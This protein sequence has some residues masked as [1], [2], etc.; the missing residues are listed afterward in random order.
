MTVIHS[1]LS[2][3]A[4]NQ[5]LWAPGESLSLRIDS[6][7]TLI[8]DPDEATYDF[9]VGLLGFGIK[10]EAYIDFKIG[11][12]AYASLPDAGSF[13]VSYNIDVNVT[14]PAAVVTNQGA[15]TFT[16]G[17][18]NWKITTADISSV[19]FNGSP[20]AG[21]DLVLGISA[22]I[23]DIEYYYWGGSDTADDFSLV[24]YDGSI[25]LLALSLGVPSIEF[26]LFKGVK[27]VGQ[28]PTG[29]DTEGHSTGST[30]VSASGVS[31]TNFI[32]LAA[33]LDELLIGLL[34][35]IPGAGAVAK[36]LGETVF[37]E[38]E[39]D[40]H[41]YVPF[42][43][44]DKF[45]L[46]AT[47]LDI[48]AS[49]GAAI[50]ESV[51]VDIG[52]GDSTPDV[53]VTLW[54][55]NGTAALGDDGVV[56]TGWLGQNI[57]ITEPTA[58]G[59]GTVNITATY[60]IRNAVFSHTVGLG[61]NASFT[62][63][64]LMASLEG[65]WVPTGLGFELGPLFELTFP[66][67]G[68]S[69]GL[70]DFY[71]DSFRMKAGAFSTDSDTYQIFYTDTAPL[72]WNPDAI[73]AQEA[74]NQYIQFISDNEAST[75]GAVGQ[76]WT[77]PQ[78][79]VTLNNGVV[80]ATGVTNTTYTWSGT[81]LNQLYQLNQSFG[82]EN[83][84][85]VNVTGAAAQN[86][87]LNFI[88]ST[89]GN[90]FSGNIDYQSSAAAKMDALGQL[91]SPGNG[92]SY[93]YGSANFITQASPEIIGGNRGD[94]LVQY[95]NGAQY[96]D[97]AGNA[98]G[99]YDLFMANFLATDPNTSIT[100]DLADALFQN[101]A[102]ELGNGVTVRNVEAMWIVTGNADD[103]IVTYSFSDYVDLSGGND[104]VINMADGAADTI[105]GGAGDDTIHVFATPP[106]VAGL[107]PVIDRIYGGTGKDLAVHAHVSSL[108]LRVDVTE[109]G[110]SLFGAAGLAHDASLIDLTLLTKGHADTFAELL[111]SAINRDN[112]NVSLV[113]INGTPQ[114]GEVV[115]NADIEGISV[116]GSDQSDD[117][118]V[119]SGG[120][121]YIGGDGASSSY[122]TLAGSFSQYEAA[123]G[124]T[125]GLFLRADTA[126]V[127]SGPT[128][129]GDAY[130]DGFERFVIFA[131]GF[132]DNITGGSYQDT[133]VGLDGD[134][135]LDGGADTV[136][137]V[138]VGGNGND[139]LIW[140]NTGADVLLGDG[141][142]GSDDTGTDTLLIEADG[143]E[144]HGLIYDVHLALDSDQ[145]LDGEFGADASSE[146][147][148]W[149]YDSAAL[150][151]QALDLS[152]NA[153]AANHVHAVA[154]GLPNNDGFMVYDGM[155]RVNIIGSVTMD[156]LMIY[157]GG[158][159][160]DGG[161]DADDVDTF[162]A[163]FTTQKIGISLHID[164]DETLDEENNPVALG[165]QGQFL[166]N[167]ILLRGVD[168]AVI[169]AGQ[170]TDFLFGGKFDDYFDG[171]AGSDQLYGSLGNDELH[172]G[173][174]D[175]LVYWFG[176]GDDTATGGAGYDLLTIAGGDGGMS[177]RVNNVVGG[178]SSNVGASD[179]FSTLEDLLQR[180]DVPANVASVVNYAGSTS[181]THSGFEGVNVFGH[182]D[183][184]DLVLYQGGV[185]N[186]GGESAGDADI[187][188]GTF[189]SV[190]ENLDIDVSRVDEDG[191]LRH[192]RHRQRQLLWRVR[193]SFR[194]TGVR[195]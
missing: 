119:F 105:K 128:T 108:E 14:M 189:T 20:S 154:F 45:V 131:S 46:K 184:N 55:D 172:G 41:N 60:D 161:E 135:V 173:D 23:R 27:L 178:T 176:E 95:G 26:D 71:K 147:F 97:G 82:L 40:L 126:L 185:M 121:V 100:W 58:T 5:S 32:E 85:V 123:L 47:M 90:F 148:Y 10:G 63:S 44:A 150:L 96:F 80:N 155:E 109:N 181:V 9:D 49:A 167:G 39:F 24:D 33:D 18:G 21:L 42:I 76:L 43:P 104:T 89:G 72:G 127:D 130:I 188:L 75:V 166:E 29:A 28:M 92:L 195:R 25:P 142:V 157:Q 152:M 54:S 16:M 138:L 140:N 168:R 62:I 165:D 144:T 164:D 163:D 59:T 114:N 159:V 153:A 87:T 52:N 31:D 117:L 66:E 137:D 2:F 112:E 11:L 13:E 149:A 37:A 91:A 160:Y 171:G 34:E 180:F 73:G 30:V 124:A 132:A 56:G 15:T 22:G 88:K 110:L 145:Y 139:F 194:E 64:A 175:D 70:F 191:Q 192:I 4:T 7:N 156:D 129:Y 81:T 93:T 68:F 183:L 136:R 98:G 94:L 141:E 99:Q 51:K 120:H 48:G 182:D 86:L 6:G 101:V 106:A 143:N 116:F 190:T 50:T 35:K 193:A 187:F 78:T 36:V 19:G 179:N 113:Y 57:T 8:Y 74:L 67:G 77:A 1:S 61:I 125:S 83:F 102:V 177:V 174:G 115:Y 146:V 107:L 84:A 151:L 169:R 158:S 133:I 170:G 162:V 53:F 122:D 186:V 12:L 17:F 38:H 111:A 3:E 79:L 103:Y 134:D 65:S 118:I 69:A